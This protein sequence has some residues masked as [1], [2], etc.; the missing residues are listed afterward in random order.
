[1]FFVT[2]LL[3]DLAIFFPLGDCLPGP[4]LPDRHYSFAR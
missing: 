3:L 1:M 4:V 2:V